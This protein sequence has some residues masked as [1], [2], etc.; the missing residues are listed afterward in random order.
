MYLQHGV[1]GE[2][3]KPSP[4][5]GGDYGFESRTRYY[6]KG[7]YSNSQIQNLARSYNGSM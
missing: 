5:Q 2:M 4:F 3:V 6:L 1:L 7:T